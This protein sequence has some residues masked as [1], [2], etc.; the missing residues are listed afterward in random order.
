MLVD[1]VRTAHGRE[2]FEGARMLV[3]MATRCTWLTA[4]D[5]RGT[6]ADDDCDVSY[7][8]TTEIISTDVRRSS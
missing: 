7:L 2:S 1:N 3:A 5:D 4:R 6:P 8:F